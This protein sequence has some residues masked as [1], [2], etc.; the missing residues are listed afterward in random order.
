MANVFNVNNDDN[1][2]LTNR[3]EKL[4]RSAFPVAV[5]QTLNEVAFDARTGMAKAAVAS[6][7]AQRNNKSIYN[8]LGRAEK[9]K[10]FD[11]KKM[12]SVTGIFPR[13]RMEAIAKSIVTQEKG[14]VVPT[15]RT[16]I[17]L[18]TART[19]NNPNK[20]VRRKQRIGNVNY[21]PKK[22]K[23]GDFARMFSEARKA[24]NAPDNERYLEYDG[25][26]WQIKRI[27]R[28]K[29]GNRIKG[30]PVYSKSKGR[31]VKVKPRPFLK[32]AADKAVLNMSKHYRNFAVKQFRKYI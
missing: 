23:K 11:L 12:E 8:L 27:L 19:G 24:L 29:K 26:I 28:R 31:R 2:K 7:Q 17:P 18:D 16:H 3:L 20:P 15:N 21:R 9:A 4:H 14:G 32:P 1:I 25:K 10:G 6:G 13:S 22:V 5:R 30:T